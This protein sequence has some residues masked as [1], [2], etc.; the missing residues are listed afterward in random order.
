MQGAYRSSFRNPQN[1]PKSYKICKNK[2][3]NIKLWQKGSQNCRVRLL[4]LREKEKVNWS[5]NKSRTVWSKFYNGKQK[6]NL[7]S[8]QSSYYQP[9]QS[10][11]SNPKETQICFL[12][13]SH[14]CRISLMN[15]LSKSRKSVYRS[16]ISNNY[17]DN[18]K[19]EYNN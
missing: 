13:A 3:V 14:P 2:L 16:Q 8:M 18:P 6:S 5:V 10:E 7:K 19:P 1:K 17:R 11:N 9:K 15:W 12:R 4:T